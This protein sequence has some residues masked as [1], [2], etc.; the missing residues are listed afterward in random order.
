MF[1]FRGFLAVFAFT[2]AW[3]GNA[4]FGAVA[5]EPGISTLFILLNAN[6]TGNVGGNECWDKELQHYIQNKIV[7][8]KGHVFCGTYDLTL[9]TPAEFAGNLTFAESGIF[10]QAQK[11]WF[12]H[13]DLPVV[14]YYKGLGWDLEHFKRDRPDLVPLRYVVIA[15]G[16]SGLAVREYIQG[17]NYGGEISNVLFF[18]TPH[19]GSGFADQALFSK[20]PE[21]IE[22]EKSAASYSALIPLAFAAYVAGGADELRRV[23]ISLARNAVFGM[24]ANFTE[25]VRQSL[26]E[27][28][29]SQWNENSPGLWYLTQDADEDDPVYGSLIAR[30]ETSTKEVLGATQWLNSFSRSHEFEHPRYNV[31]YS[32]GF[33]TIGNGRR[34]LP[35][36]VEQDK[37]HVSKEKLK[38]IVSDSISSVLKKQGVDLHKLTPEIEELA[39]GLLS[40]EVSE[41]VREVAD[42][43]MGKYSALKGVLE[44]EKLA[45]YLQGVSELRTLKWNQD[46]VPGSVLK[47]ISVLE[48]FIPEEYKS[49]LFSVFTDKFSR[50]SLSAIENFCAIGNSSVRE[51]AQKGMG[52]V[53]KNLSNYSLNFFDMG[54][55]DVPWYSAFGE[56]VAAFKEAT[57]NR[58][59][60]AIDKIV[61]DNREEFKEL[62]DYQKKLND[63]GSLER[64]REIVDTALN[65]GCGV[66][67]KTFSL[68]GKVC[69]AAEFAANVGLMAETSAKVKDV[70]KASKA[71]AK[72]GDVALWAAMRENSFQKIRGF[73][74]KEIDVKFSDLDSM[75]YT[76]PIISVAGVFRTREGAADSV[77]PLMFNRKCEGEIYDEA[78][79]KKSCKA[80]D[81]DNPYEQL[82][83]ASMK[84]LNF[85][86]LSGRRILPLKWVQFEKDEKGILRR[87]T[88]YGASEYFVTE[89]FIREFRF[90]IDDISPDSLRLVKVEFSSGIR[91]AYERDEMGLWT[92]YYGE[93]PVMKM[94]KSPVDKR[95]EFIFRPEEILEKAGTSLSAAEEDGLNIVNVYVV[96]KLGLSDSREFAFFFKATDWLLEEGFPENGAMVSSLGNPFVYFGTLAYPVKVKHGGVR[97]SKWENGQI[98]RLDSVEAGLTFGNQFGN[99]LVYADLDKK[100]NGK[101][102]EGEYLLEWD[103]AYEYSEGADTSERHSQLAVFAY[104][105]TTPPKLKWNLPLRHLKGLP[106]EEKWGMLENEDAESNLGIRAMRVFAVGGK[107][108]K[109]TV[110][111]Y[112]SFGTANRIYR[113]GW[114][115]NVKTLNGK[116]SL[117]AQ[118][119]DYSIPD[120]LTEDR[121]QKATADTSDFWSVVLDANGKFIRGIN[122]VDLSENLWIDA[123]APKV[124][125]GSLQTEILSKKIEADFSPGKETSERFLLN[126]QDALKISFDIQEEHSDWVSSEIRLDLIFV[127]SVNQIKRTFSDSVSFQTPR[128]HYSFEESGENRLADGEY[129]LIVRLKDFSGNVSFD[130]LLHR[131]VV[132]RTS[133][134]VSG[135]Y[136]GDVAFASAADLNE[137][138]AYVNQTADLP[139]NRSDLRCFSKLQ[140]SEMSTE[141]RGLD[142]K[143]DGKL[144]DEKWTL[145]INFSK[146][147]SKTQ[148]PDG[149]WTVFLRCYDAAGNWG[150]NSDFFGMGA[151]Y[152]RFTGLSDSLNEMFFGN[153]LLRGFAP[154]P[155]IRGGNDNLAEFRIDWKPH[156]SGEDA[157]TENGIVYLSSG[158]HS[159]ERSLAIWKIPKEAAGVYDVR[160][161]VCACKENNACPWYSSIREI[162]VYP[163]VFDEKEK[164]PFIRFVN[165]PQNQIPGRNDSVAFEIRGI[166]DTAKWAVQAS[167]EVES[168]TAPGTWAAEKTVLFDPVEISPFEGEPDGLKNGLS[169]WKGEDDVWNLRWHGEASGWMDSVNGNR[170]P[171]SL[172]FKYLKSQILFENENTKMTQLDSFQE[173]SS[174]NVG[175]A[176]IPGYDRNAKWLLNGD[177]LFIRFR[178][179]GAF[180]VD[181]S[182]V[183]GGK[184]K[185][186]CGGSGRLASEISSASYGTAILYVHPE[187]YRIQFDFDGLTRAGLYP[188]G[189]QARLKLFAYDKKDA[190][191]VLLDSASWLFNLG[192]PELKSSV[193]DTGTFYLGLPDSVNGEISLAKQNLG[194]SF[195]LIGKSANVSAWV[196]SPDGAVVKT[197]MEKE[198]KLAGSNPQAYTL[199]WNG[200][201]DD[202]FAATQEGLYRI[203]VKAY[204]DENEAVS[205]LVYPFE[206]KYATGLVKAPESFHGEAAAELS[207]DEALEDESGLRF[208]GDLDYLMR[209]DAEAMFLPEEERSFRYRWKWDEEHPGVQYPAMYKLYRPSLGIWRQRDKFNVAVVT[210]LISYAYGLTSYPGCNHQSRAISYQIRLRNVLFDRSSPE[211]VFDFS[212]K[213]QN[214]SII[215][216]G[217]GL[218]RYPI[219]MAVKVLPAYEI[220]NLVDSFFGSDSLNSG[221]V[222]Y[223]TSNDWDVF[224]KDSVLNAGWYQKKN[225]A[226]ALLE[227]F[228]NWGGKTVYWEG[229]S[230]NG[231]S[232][233]FWYDSPRIPIVPE[234]SLFGLDKKCAV[235]LEENAQAE[236]AICED[237]SSLIKY[238]VYNPHAN[239]LNVFVEGNGDD[240]TY[241][242]KNRS[243]GRCDGRGNSLKSIEGKIHLRVNDSYWDNTEKGWGYNN[244]ANRYLRLDPTN[245]TL[246][247][248]DGYLGHFP[249][250]D[251]LFNKHDG[252]KMVNCVFG[253]RE[254]PDNCKLSAF[255]SLY[256]AMRDVDDNP[257]LFPDERP[258]NTDAGRSFWPS[259]YRWNFFNATDDYMALAVNSSTG[260]W[261]GALERNELFDYTDPKFINANF[262]IL[263]LNI[264]FWVAPKISASGALSPSRMPKEAFDYPYLG[265]EEMFRTAFSKKCHEG[266]RCYPGFASRLHYGIGDWTEEDWE[267]EFILDGYLRN[268]VLAS[269]MGGKAV[270]V[271]K[272]P[273]GRTDALDSVFEYKVSV[274]DVDANGRW[275]VPFERLKTLPL[276]RSVY[277]HPVTGELV[278]EILRT[279]S[280]SSWKEESDALKKSFL[281]KAGV[282]KK[283]VLE[284]IRSKDFKRKRVGG[285]VSHTIPFA[286]VLFQNPKDS[287]FSSPW[288][289]KKN[290]TGW[291]MF[292]RDSLNAEHP[293]LEVKL[294][295]DKT[296]NFDNALFSV[297]VEEIPFNRRV[298][299]MATLRGRVPG[300][301]SKWKLFY[302]KGGMLFPAA[303]GMQ[304]TVP[305][306][307]PFPVLDYLNVN[308]LQGNTSFFLT[309]GA[310]N[311]AMYFRQLDV[312][313]GNLVKPEESHEIRSMYGNVSVHFPAGAWGENAVDVTVRTISA[314]DYNFAA[315][316]GFDWVGPILEVLPSHEFSD[317]TRLPE[318]SVM[319]PRSTIESK[320]LDVSNLKIYKPNFKTG[321]IVALETEMAGYYLGNDPVDVSRFPLNEKNWDRVRLK[322][323]TRSF[324]TFFVTDADK[325]S[326]IK[327]E[328]SPSEETRELSC[329][330]MP[331]DTLW[332][333]TFNGWIE[334]PYPCRGNSNYRLQLRQKAAVVTEHQGVSESPFIWNVRQNEIA[335]THSE[336]YDSRVFFYGVDGNT[337][338]LRGPSVRLDSVAPEL[339]G[340]VSVDVL[341]RGPEKILRVESA[342]SDVGSGIFQTRFD[343]YFGGNLLES[344]TV[345]VDS[346]LL[347]D[348]TISQ[349]DLYQCVGCFATV[350]VFV[351]DVGHNS[352]KT[353]LK[354]EPLYPYPK[355]LV[356]WYPFA[357]GAGSIAYEMMG[358]GMDMT[359]ETVSKPWMNGKSLHLFR[360]E[361]A[362][363][364]RLLEKEKSTPFSVEMQVSAGKNLGAILSWLG[365]IPWTV[366][367]DENRHY[368][369][370]TPSERTVF[371]A[372]AEFAVKNHLVWTVDGKRASLYRNGILVEEKT[373]PAILEWSGNGKFGVGN[374][375]VTGNRSGFTGYLSA[376][377]FYRSA[378]SNDQV[379]RLYREGLDLEEGGEAF[380]RAVNLGFD[381]LTVDQ[382]CGVAGKSYLRQKSAQSRGLM[383]WNVEVPADEYAVY[384][385]MRGRASEKSEVEILV[386][387]HSYGTAQIRS[388]GMWKSHR[389]ES[390]VLNL[391]S[392]KNAIQLR[393]SDNLGIAGVAVVS[394]KKNRAADKV[395][396]GEGEWK[397][398]EPKVSV[399]MQYDSPEDDTWSRM[400]FQI[401]NLTEERFEFA[402]IRY[403]Y[404]GEG[405]AV[406]SQ[407]F[408]PG[409]GLMGIFPDAGTVRYAEY[410]LT[411]PIEEK[412]SVKKN[413]PYFGLYRWPD[414][415][416]WNIKDDPSYEKMAE[417]QFAEASGVAVLD[418]DGKL[419]NDWTCFDEDGGMDS[420]K[421]KVRALAGDEKFGSSLGS[422][423]KVVIENVGKLVVQGFEVRYYFREDGEKIALS[424]YDSV[425][426][427]VELVN[428]GGD[429]HYVSLFYPEAILN[430]GERSAFGNGAKFELYHSDYSAD[431]NALDDPSHFGIRGRELVLADSVVVLDLYGNLMWGNAPRPA[432]QEKIVVPEDN[433][434]ILFREGD[435]VYVVVES[436]DSYSL[437]VVNAAGLPLE[438][439]FKGV[440]SQGEHAVDISGIHPLPGTYLVLRRGNQIL[441]WQ[442]LK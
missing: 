286:S 132:D 49:E 226:K 419:L 282:L 136:S 146:W 77:I 143:T 291:G 217:D 437:Q 399:K 359:L 412:G 220:K 191:R 363:G 17:V 156:E 194:Y 97:I 150:E 203:L 168:Q 278:P 75:L 114:N 40:G 151:R 182:S 60:Y 105:D 142:L 137:G 238:N 397:N 303:S 138:K 424:V 42:K 76:V 272:N 285:E 145:S 295:K 324:S 160:L 331:L 435:V 55:F 416:P 174:L 360:G 65:I 183:E 209:V 34:T 418:A 196:I 242:K 165:L 336:V 434:E 84:E 93:R 438:T 104:V 240:F 201:T 273:P 125:K 91:I 320:K 245:K 15:N 340:D 247:S 153:V 231:N 232:N 241:G 246:F 123:E 382:S 344:R 126:Q 440:W 284:Y 39:E 384:L 29:F 197:L 50:N 89:N 133:P 80:E 312:H 1:G 310:S 35:D 394:V 251:S 371:A 277:G 36:F 356:L 266:F 101:W 249:K 3:I 256:F 83:D 20:H 24:T 234:A 184:E 18:N 350:S 386:N 129:Q 408:Y 348:F 177:D 187:R 271:N 202:N 267:S 147:L 21:A 325:A 56:N 90:Q 287:L 128:F 78:S 308:E 205:E 170:L 339:K 227:W 117:H 8:Q 351:E 210:L 236:N 388:N 107:E 316:R 218:R 414:Y 193:S 99:V 254:N 222:G 261:I 67:E 54:T 423:V 53:A 381:G 45:G 319:I 228:D 353:T 95:G 87:R 374:L 32:E 322:A 6:S 52:V 258:I 134:V 192:T 214:R 389:I 391:K 62:Y 383:T 112:R 63:L 413:A 441:T 163:K 365:E 115:D 161:S 433:G 274:A 85:S 318:V 149:V 417:S 211:A 337:I 207:M 270:N 41:H 27:T 208:V 323:V 361:H 370:E 195:G 30:A 159:A 411:S 292:R 387:G 355:S 347:E 69:R 47:V 103:I 144:S 212:Y 79:M 313:I 239:M 305:E 68:S 122:G 106:S 302:T 439:L 252:E 269:Q 265:S 206:L 109:D 139:M 173:I 64:S 186:F 110:Y 436:K 253:M 321:E 37:N 352:V 213:P 51:C 333:G 198:K 357:E 409:G 264:H 2:I 426:A 204:H 130:T 116:V 108:N 405:S 377:R 221:N 82:R 10:S 179:D 255:E 169:I 74:G 293:Y 98:A 315:F 22:K 11:N 300:E 427:K 275:S 167:L 131:I 431:F 38:R 141:W 398:P 237:D 230:W 92:V 175:G 281:V 380:A 12:E 190:N 225:S 166:S 148:L 294:E 57:T 296:E 406:A 326:Q 307:T 9:Q 28:Y 425:G 260:K 257:L 181:L 306:E 113:I 358:T 362:T 72:T 395:N 118:A 140:V 229:T 393:P 404:K 86:T 410:E 233:L 289:Q 280:S 154:N 199:K 48:K 155:A 162:P 349:K 420:E 25:D 314:R 375:T 372:R 215:G 396:Y 432:F 243:I 276:F 235:S 421:E 59:G 102:E 327:W 328:N 180:T 428:A 376:V 309:Y 301:N 378:L 5:M 346:V 66:L 330:E 120:G 121:M 345:P 248:E 172:N 96:N 135:V 288:F 157:W 185:I 402:R 338:S 311:D 43:I 71:L 392:G 367:I 329:G 14:Q 70:V 189:E 317:T 279:N 290:I 200:M 366:G 111:L 152:P 94:E 88:F 73:N 7:G 259:R 298:E 342:A 124:V 334:Y 373:L 304:D 379:F 164:M 401:E 100:F 244:L 16:A 262:D 26:N 23:V 119:I 283:T 430:P 422:V 44:N 176:E 341:E 297:N 390:M 385:L 171:P 61:A 4:A 13:S 127:D 442:L 299:E 364:T 219:L 415:R 19:E 158:V 368:Y 354:S 429:L 31:I 369:L 188:G 33:P 400:R 46:D 403:Y 178:A 250:S 407:V 332:A 268:N 81:S 223:D 224:W 335:G 263:P 216:Y 343:V 58:F